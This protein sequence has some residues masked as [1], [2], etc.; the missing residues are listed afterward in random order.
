MSCVKI[1]LCEHIKIIKP[2]THTRYTVNRVVRAIGSAVWN[3]I[4]NVGMDQELNVGMWE[5]RRC[6]ECKQAT[7]PFTIFD[8][9]DNTSL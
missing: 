3:G 9:K 8:M 7:V 2:I 4:V 1:S 6:S 5:L